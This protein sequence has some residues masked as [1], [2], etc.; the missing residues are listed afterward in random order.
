MCIRDRYWTLAITICIHYIVS[1]YL[2]S[3]C[4]FCFSNCSNEDARFHDITLCS[5]K[6]WNWIIDCKMIDVFP[7]LYIAYRLLF[8]IP[9]PNWESERAFS[10]LKRL[11]IVEFNHGRRQT[12]FVSN[13]KRDT[14][15][16]RF[17]RNY[18][19]LRLGKI[20][21]KMDRL[22]FAKLKYYYAHC[23]HYLTKHLL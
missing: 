11:K 5:L 20:K 12:I 10:V 19:R 16:A 14:W 15:I 6:L 22:V 2:P 21:K 3:R 8:T 17:R 9:I 13:I 18:T 7:N 23:N 4:R 1:F